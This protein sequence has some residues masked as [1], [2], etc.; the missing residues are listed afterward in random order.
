MGMTVAGIII[1]ACGAAVMVTF[2]RLI[3]CRFLMREASSGIDV[4]LKKRHDLIPN[5]VD[6]VKGY[7][8]YE[9]GVLGDITALRGR[10]MESGLTLKERGDQESGL[11]G[12]I[13]NVFALAEDYPEL[14]A[15]GAL[16]DLQR[17]LSK[18]E[19][20][21]QYAR[22]YYNGAVRDYNTLVESFPC[23]LVAALFH[24]APAD[25][26]EIEYA[27]ERQV[28]DVRFDNA[29]PAHLSGKTDGEKDERA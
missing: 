14:K 23:N 13:K 7:M 2:N 24:F 4:Q 29:S 21:L 27:T 20:D 18:V 26:F 1:A 16:L 15:D 17:G 22:R 9:R 6:A 5:I 10:S 8:Q 3:R 11:S 28:H 25:F 12:L 19:D